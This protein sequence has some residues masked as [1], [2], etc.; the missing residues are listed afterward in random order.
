MANLSP[1]SESPSSFHSHP[2]VG[3]VGITIPTIPIKPQ[4]TTT[5]KTTKS[6]PR[7][8]VNT[9]EKRS[10][11]NAIERA[12]RET[13][14]GKFLSLARLLP[15]L[16]TVRRPS[17]SAIVNGS[18]S[19]LTHQRDQ[20][21]LAA[22]IL[23]EMKAE[24]DDLLK[25]VNEWRKMNGYSPKESANEYTDEI[26]Q[27][28]SVEKE[29]FGEFSAMDGDNDD[30]DQE[31]DDTPSTN[32]SYDSIN[33]NIAAIH[34]NFTQSNGLITP[35]SSTDID[36]TLQ[37]SLYPSTSPI[38]QRIPTVP[39]PVS[40]AG[41]TTGVNWST[42]FALNLNQ[43]M[44]NPTPSTA[45]GQMNFVDTPTHSSFVDTPT[46]SSSPINIV[47]PTSDPARGMNPHHTPSPGSSHSSS[48]DPIVNV[49]NGSGGLPN[50]WNSQQLAMLEQHA[51]QA[52][53]IM[54]EHHQAQQHQLFNP[55]VGNT[56][57][58]MFHSAPTTPSSATATGLNSF[59]P[60]NG[61]GH[62]MG[63]ELTQQMLS[64][65]FP[66]SETNQVSVQ[67]IHNAIRAGMG[68]GMGM[69]MNFGSANGGNNSPWTPTQA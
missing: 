37:Q 9:A 61:M 21:L 68:L 17:K 32:D 10:Q 1:I 36:S 8:R 55:M 4:N 14:N 58:A 5:G 2:S 24:R 53:T 3:H 49:S 11:H 15:S 23:K 44:S 33:N 13:L 38:D 69:G 45:T 25:E 46:H 63:M 22:R 16:A 39:T 19:H 34:G 56:F 35:R 40:A 47:S 48:V 20:R 59:N 31:E 12:R 29:S 50:G 30:Q 42:E 28:N 6:K 18:I 27:I 43:Q 52:H 57:N 67:D 7:K 54:R 64:T 26:D 62:G 65:M 66:R 51:A 41:N 60:F